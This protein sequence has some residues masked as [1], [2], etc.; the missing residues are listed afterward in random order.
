MQAKINQHKINRQKFTQVKIKQQVRIYAGKKF[1]LNSKQ[2]EF[3]AV[4]YTTYPQ[5]FFLQNYCHSESFNHKILAMQTFWMWGWV[6]FYTRTLA[7]VETYRTD[8]TNKYCTISTV[9]DEMYTC[10]SWYK[11]INYEHSP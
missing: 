1:Q 7:A 10:S 4:I 2:G 6:E 5:I 8:F 3:F 11:R 9:N